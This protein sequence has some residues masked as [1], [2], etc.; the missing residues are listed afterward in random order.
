MC[1][2]RVAEGL[3]GP[4]V[5]VLQ[6]QCKRIVVEARVKW[7]VCSL[8][9]GQPARYCFMVRTILSVYWRPSYLTGARDL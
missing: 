9:E 3:Y 7:P 1:V 5:F 8:R 2:Q 6:C 4:L